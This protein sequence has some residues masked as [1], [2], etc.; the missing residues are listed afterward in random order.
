MPVE[1]LGIAATN[2][3]SETTPRS[4]ASSNALVGTP[5]TVA[6]ALLDYD[7]LGVDILSARGY[8]LLGDA[9][10]SGRQVIPIVRAEVVGRDARRT[11]RGP[12]TLAADSPTAG[13]PTAVRE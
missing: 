5:E 2:N 13:N 9:I 6:R 12:H 8:D 10:D 11:E 3:G 4:G 7:D 1:F